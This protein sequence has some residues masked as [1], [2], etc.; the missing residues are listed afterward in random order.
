MVGTKV[1]YKRGIPTLA[2]LGIAK[3][4]VERD[5][6]LRLLGGLVGDRPLPELADLHHD[7][8]ER[9]IQWC[10]RRI[11]NRI[12]PCRPVVECGLRCD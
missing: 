4:S 11:A 3:T 2:L 6:A 10:Y 9:S 8:I 12:E 5:A 7:A 1:S